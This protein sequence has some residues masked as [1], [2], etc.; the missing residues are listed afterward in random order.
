MVMTVVKRLLRLDEMT[1]HQ[2]ES[3]LPLVIEGS[4]DGA[5]CE[6]FLAY[7]HAHKLE[8]DAQIHKHGAILFRGFAIDQPSQFEDAATRLCGGLAE[9]YPFGMAPRNK[10]DGTG[11]VFTTTKSVHTA[12]HDL[13]PIG[14]HN[15]MA[16][17]SYA[18][19]R[20]AFYCQVPPEPGRYGETIIADTR[21]IYN[22]MERSVRDKFER[23][24]VRYIRE[25][26]DRPGRFGFDLSWQMVFETSDKDEVARV[27]RDNGAEIEW[28]GDGSV[29]V[30]NWRPAVIDHPVIGERT[31]A[32]CSGAAT[33]RGTVK[34]ILWNGGPFRYLHAWFYRA[35]YAMQSKIAFSLAYGDGTPIPNQDIEAVCE[36]QDREKVCFQW[37]HGDLLILDNWLVSHGRALLRGGRRNILAAFG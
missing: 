21:A 25:Y 26:R 4:G 1:R 16:Y 35:M 32:N 13:I 29:R 2:R 9:N 8:I 37:R 20:I 10:V 23:L 5:G 22:R 3:E 28:F 24:G 33:L 12:H 11:A 31:W 30:C 27:C 17:S 15:E 34:E 36:A 14:L 6:N 18:P 7:L 19:D